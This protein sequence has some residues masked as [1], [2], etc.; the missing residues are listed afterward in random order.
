VP[1]EQRRKKETPCR[2]VRLAGRGF[3]VYN[4]GMKE[5]F[6]KDGDFS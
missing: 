3:F 1:A 2:R 5:I 4:E 6:R